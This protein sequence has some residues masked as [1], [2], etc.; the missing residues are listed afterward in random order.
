LVVLNRDLEAERNK[1]SIEHK[2][3]LYSDLTQN[4]DFTEK[5]KFVSTKGVFDNSADK[6]TNSNEDVKTVNEIGASLC[7]MEGG[8]IS[9][10]CT[11]NSIP[12]VMIKGITDIFGNGTS[13]EQFY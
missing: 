7:D 9:Q 3:D 2:A 1:F 4:S 5:S 10:V 11:S 6:F 13:S 12:L 8:A